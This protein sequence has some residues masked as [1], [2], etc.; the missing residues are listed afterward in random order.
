MCH[1]TLFVRK[2]TSF[3]SAS[4]LFDADFGLV[5]SGTPEG[6]IVITCLKKRSPLLCVFGGS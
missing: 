2:A 4:S 1:F 5:I 6:R 3:L